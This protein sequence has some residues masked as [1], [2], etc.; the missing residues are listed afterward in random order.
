MSYADQLTPYQIYRARQL[1]DF[2]A[3]GYRLPGGYSSEGL[4]ITFTDKDV[5]H[6]LLLYGRL[7]PLSGT[8]EYQLGAKRRRRRAHV[9]SV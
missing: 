6:Y 5:F 7:V 3:L 2:L 1:R 8:V 4:H 9:P